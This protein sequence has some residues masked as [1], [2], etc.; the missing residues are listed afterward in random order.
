MPSPNQCANYCPRN[1]LLREQFISAIE[2]EGVMTGNFVV[3]GASIGYLDKDYNYCE[4]GPQTD[5][6]DRRGPLKLLGPK[7]LYAC[8]QLCVAASEQ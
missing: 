5:L 4:G 1:I 3:S 6:T 2:Q 7:T 8:G